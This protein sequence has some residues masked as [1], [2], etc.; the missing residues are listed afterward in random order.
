MSL[1]V[2]LLL[3]GAVSYLGVRSY[4]AS[5]AAAGGS[6]YINPSSDSLASGST[7]SFT[8]RENSGTTPINSVQFSLKYDPSQLQYSSISPSGDFNFNGPVS[9]DTP[10][11]IRMQRGMQ[12][13]HISGD[14]PVANIT[15][16]VLAASGS[17]SLNFE[18]D[19]TFQAGDG[20]NITEAITGGTY[21]I[22][23]AATGAAS[24]PAKSATL[25]LSP[26]GG[27]LTKGSTMTVDVKVANPTTPI[28]A[29]E[30]ALN[31]PANQLQF[32][33]ASNS[34]GFPSALR[35][36]AGSGTLDIIRGIAPGGP[37]FI[38][39]ATVVTLKFKVIGSSGDVPIGFTN[40][41]EVDDGDGKNLLAGTKGSAFAIGSPISNTPPPATNNGSGDG[42][43]QPNSPADGSATKTSAGSVYKKSVAYTPQ[44]GGSAS[45]SGDATQVGGSVVIRPVADPL[46][47]V[48]NAEDTITKVEYYIDGNLVATRTSA[49]FTYALDT[50]K[51]VNGSHALTIKTHYASGHI[52]S[53][54]DKLN[55][56]NPI[57][58]SYILAHYS[59]GIVVTIAA[60]V[61]VAL[62]VWKLLLPRFSKS[63]PLAATASASA[64]FGGYVGSGAGQLAS[65]QA[66]YNL[67]G[68]SLGQTV[69]TPNADNPQAYQPT[70]PAAPAP[71][72]PGAPQPPQPG[73]QQGSIPT[74]IIVPQ[75][76][77][78]PRVSQPE[79][80]ENPGNLGAS[81]AAPDSSRP[82]NPAQNQDTQDSSDRPN[83][84]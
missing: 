69:V 17:T 77:A 22:T 62:V 40:K 26:E 2:A 59:T 27:E 48:K 19:K 41:S 25:T 12:D 84:P 72:A 71:M 61:I 23:G 9:T 68:G 45:I 32:D 56:S 35:T 21:M 53:A 83:Y 8:V 66:N 55:V 42:S 16:K 24:D 6:I 58:L 82:E 63:T 49:P 10:G 14:H 18:T 15:F 76:P 7:V 81:E 36:Q 31:Y 51:L 47:L 70:A 39:S 3:M 75:L 4:S 46:T 33:S 38:G 13:S 43:T 73:V 54:T 5:H 20:Q 67:N 60:L 80:P 1:G 65:N 64:G 78:Q 52:E 29:I 57:T 50:T 30:A 79:N 37:G 11:I 34:S 28:Y 74:E 44:D